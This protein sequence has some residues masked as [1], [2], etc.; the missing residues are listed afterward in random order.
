[1][2][3]SVEMGTSLLIEKGTTLEQEY[4]SIGQCD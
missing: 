3:T 4:T 2:V 1:M